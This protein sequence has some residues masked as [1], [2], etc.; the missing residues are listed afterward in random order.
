MELPQVASLQ[1]NAQSL[2]R[3]AQYMGG[4]LTS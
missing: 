2:V 1:D 4:P 3:A